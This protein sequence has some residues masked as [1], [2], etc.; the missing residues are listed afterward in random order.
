MGGKQLHNE[1]LFSKKIKATCYGFPLIFQLRMLSS[2]TWLKPS[3]KSTKSM[4]LFKRDEQ[5]VYIKRSNNK[6]ID[7]NML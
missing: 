1:K 5:H 3:E 2:F 6:K 7:A 4:I